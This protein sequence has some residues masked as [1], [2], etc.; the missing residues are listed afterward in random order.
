[1]NASFP[2]RGLSGLVVLCVPLGVAAQ[3]LLRGAEP[4]VARVKADPPEVQVARLPSGQ[5]LKR[6]PGDS[7]AVN[8]ATSVP[9]APLT[10]LAVQQVGNAQVRV[11]NGPGST[12]AAPAGVAARAAELSL[13]QV[14]QA[15]VLEVRGERSPAL[16]AAA[17]SAAL[18]AGVAI[19]DLAPGQALPWP[20]AP[21]TLYRRATPGG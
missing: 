5:L 20:P 2:L 16:P 15:Q 1:M 9:A 8:A 3:G 6:L 17:A 18:P 12:A 4:A 7:L 10:G 21:N 19:V 11:L 13:R 14:G